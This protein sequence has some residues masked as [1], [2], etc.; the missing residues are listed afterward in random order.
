VTDNRP[1]EIGCP[2]VDILADMLRSALIWEQNH[3]QPPQCGDEDTLTSMPPHIYTDDIPD[4]RGGK[5]NDDQENYHKDKA[6][7]DL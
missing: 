3:G 6:R 5:H 4:R 7:N 2:L 1:S